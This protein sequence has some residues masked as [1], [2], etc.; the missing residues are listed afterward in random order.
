MKPIVDALKVKGGL[1]IIKDDDPS[2]CKIM[3]PEII[4]IKEKDGE[5]IEIV[6]TNR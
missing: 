1:G 4:Q 2:N 3:V 5:H 6:I